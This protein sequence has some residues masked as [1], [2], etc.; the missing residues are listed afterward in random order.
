MLMLIYNYADDTEL[1]FCHNDFRQLEY[2]LQCAVTKLFNWLVANKLKLSIPKSS[3][4]L[5]GTQ[6]RTF[7]RTLHLSLNSVPLRQV[8]T[9]WYLG[10][11]IDQHLTWHHHVE[12]VYREFVASCI[13]LIALSYSLL[14]WWSY[15]IRHVF[16]QLLT[17]VMLY[18]CLLML[19]ISKD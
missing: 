4:M 7:G 18:G 11:Y 12:Y 14:M 6:Q 17:T 5:I 13:Q 9:I 3:C 19:V 10:V 15:C 16:Y 8:S 1:H 2:Y